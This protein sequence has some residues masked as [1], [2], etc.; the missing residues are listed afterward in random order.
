MIL[1][2]VGRLLEGEV[3]LDRPAREPG[4]L[5]L[6]R[7]QRRHDEPEDSEDRQTGKE[8]EE[9][10]KLPAAADLP[11]EPERDKELETDQQPQREGIGAGAVCR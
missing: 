6:A 2:L 9:E 8:T 1:G 7:R 11:R 5:G 10:G 3:V 4:L